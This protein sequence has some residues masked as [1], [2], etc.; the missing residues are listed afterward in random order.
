V[1]AAADHGALSM[2]PLFVFE[3]CSHTTEHTDVDAFH[4]QLALLL[5][6]V[7]WLP[8]ISTLSFL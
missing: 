6:Y 7:R 1:L 3:C 2:L 8:L 4:M 5:P